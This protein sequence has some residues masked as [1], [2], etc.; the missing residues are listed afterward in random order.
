[1]LAVGTVVVVGGWW[2]GCR[3]HHDNS[4]PERTC[5]NERLQIWQDPTTSFEDRLP[6]KK[7]Y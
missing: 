4:D 2:F 1:V 5:R 7:G 3:E 6:V